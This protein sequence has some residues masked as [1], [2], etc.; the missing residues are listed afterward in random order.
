MTQEERRTQFH[1]KARIGYKRNSASLNDCHNIAERYY[2]KE[3][4]LGEALGLAWAAGCEY[5]K[6]HAKELNEL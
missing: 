2:K 4:T 3:L 6:N 5:G 1:K